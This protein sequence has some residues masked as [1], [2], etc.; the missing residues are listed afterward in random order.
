MTRAVAMILADMDQGASLDEALARVGMS[1]NHELR[2]NVLAARRTR[3]P[4]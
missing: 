1:N 4:A 3:T 2:R